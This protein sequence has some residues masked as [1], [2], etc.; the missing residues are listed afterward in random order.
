MGP[1][2][3]DSGRGDLG[4]GISGRGDLGG[5]LGRGDLGRGDSAA[6][7]SGRGDLGRGDLGAGPGRGDL[8]R[9]DL[10]RGDLGRGDLGGGDLFVGDPDSPG[11]ELDFETATELA[12]TPPNEFTA[13]VAA[14]GALASWKAPN[15]GGVTGYSV[16]RV[17]G[18]AL[19]ADMAAW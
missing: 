3:L 17:P 4:A 15:I 7:T 1:L 12:K 9:G 8:G 11:G 14:S 19:R 16:Y 6:G 10:G 5:E 13:T 18:N 2:S